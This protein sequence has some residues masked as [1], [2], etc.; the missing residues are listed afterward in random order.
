MENITFGVLASA[1]LFGSTTSTGAAIA[2]DPLSAPVTHVNSA[3]QVTA[4][5][6]SSAQPTSQSSVWNVGPDTSTA[7]GGNRIP[8]ALCDNPLSN[9][10]ALGTDSLVALS[11]WMSPIN[12]CGLI[13]I[14]I[15][16]GETDYFGTTSSLA[17]SSPLGKEPHDRFPDS[18][19]TESCSTSCW[20]KSGGNSSRTPEAAPEFDSRFAIPGF[21]LFLGLL[22]IATDR[23]FRPGRKSLRSRIIP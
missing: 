20:N 15:L 8:F 9:S 23:R 5:P 19:A 21:G 11:F 6:T 18:G 12:D 7:D 17:G 13:Q 16:Q 1:I 4:G 2:P 3:L 14:G 22:A 10:T